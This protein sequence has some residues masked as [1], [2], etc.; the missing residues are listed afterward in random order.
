MSISTIFPSFYVLLKVARLSCAIGLIFNIIVLTYFILMVQLL[1][2][3]KSSKFIMGMSLIGLIIQVLIL[4]LLIIGIVSSERIAGKMINYS[5]HLNISILPC[6]IITSGSIVGYQNK[7]LG[8]IIA[9]IGGFSWY[10]SFYFLFFLYIVV[11]LLFFI[12]LFII[13][14]PI[15]LGKITFSRPNYKKIKIIVLISAILILTLPYPII[16]LIDDHP[17]FITDDWINLDKIASISKFRSQAGHEYNDIYEKLSSQKHY[18]QPNVTYGDSTNQIEIYS[19][20]NGFITNVFY[21][22]DINE[23]KIRGYQVWIRPFAVPMYKVV[24]FHINLDP[25]II[26]GGW[27]SSGQKIGYASVPGM[28]NIDIAIHIYLPLLGV[29]YISYFEIMN[30]KVF[31]KYQARGISTRDE[32]IIPLSIAEKYTGWEQNA[33]R[34]WFN[35]N[36]I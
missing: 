24:L 10:F 28:T 18:F 14:R 16:K 12:G 4:V 33:T 26:I 7:S 1:R 29:K 34:D 22:G 30:N 2:E 20:V 17:Q 19:P 27:V 35:L 31:S 11:V 3:F 6:A 8:I 23:G 32:M 5:L 21:E 36:P 15:E 25:N 13:I 9:L